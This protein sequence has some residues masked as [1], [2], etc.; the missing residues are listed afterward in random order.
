MCITWLDYT[1][2]VTGTITAEKEDH[3]EDQPKE[4]RNLRAIS[5]ALSRSVQGFCS[6]DGDGSLKAWY[7]QDDTIIMRD[8]AE[9]VDVYIA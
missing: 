1:C 6:T 7:F 9:R 2:K 3:F 8:V 4:V 5:S